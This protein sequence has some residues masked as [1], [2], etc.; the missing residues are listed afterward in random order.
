MEIS[1]GVF[2]GQ[3]TARVRELMWLRVL[4]L[5]KEGNAI[6]VHSSGNEQ[7]LEYR[8]HRHD[9]QPEEFDGIWLMRRPAE[10]STVPALPPGWSTVGRMK[11]ARRYRK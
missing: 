8:C 7:G 1:P 2:V 5:C 11:R 9:W 6:M 3:V 4:E 10:P